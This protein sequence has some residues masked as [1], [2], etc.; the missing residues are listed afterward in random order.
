MKSWISGLVQLSIVVLLAFTVAMQS[1]STFGKKDAKSNLTKIDLLKYVCEKHGENA[2]METSCRMFATGGK[3]ASQSECEIR[4]NINASIAIRKECEPM[5]ADLESLRKSCE[6]SDDV[7]KCINFYLS[8]HD[9][10]RQKCYDFFA[11][12]K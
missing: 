10:E 4:S 3:G 6:G 2:C 7:K 5:K 12:R 11:K 1:C 9:L 8:Y